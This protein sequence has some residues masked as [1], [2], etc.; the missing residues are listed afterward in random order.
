[1]TVAAARADGA[2]YTARVKEIEGSGAVQSQESRGGANDE[3]VVERAEAHVG[4]AGLLSVVLD[5]GPQRQRRQLPQPHCTV[6]G[7]REQMAGAARERSERFVA[8]CH[9]VH[10]RAVVQAEHAD[11]A[12]RV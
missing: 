8:C 9:G 4:N 3:H 6:T 2:G 5:D 7:A 12:A 11:A 10:G 1:M